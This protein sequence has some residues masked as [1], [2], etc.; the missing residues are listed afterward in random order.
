LPKTNCSSSVTTNEYKQFH[1]NVTLAKDSFPPSLSKQSHQLPQQQQ[2]QQHLDGATTKSQKEQSI[3]IKWEPNIDIRNMKFGPSFLSNEKR[4]KCSSFAVSARERESFPDKDMFGAVTDDASLNNNKL[5]DNGLLSNAS[6]ACLSPNPSVWTPYSVQNSDGNDFVHN[7]NGSASCFSMK[8][9]SARK[10]KKVGPLMAELRSLRGSIEGDWVRFQSGTYPYRDPSKRR[11]DVNDP[12]NRAEYY[13]DVTILSEPR[14]WSREG[15]KIVFLG[16][17][18]NKVRIKKRNEIVAHSSC[19]QSMRFRMPSQSI[20]AINTG[21]AQATS[22]TSET[23][24]NG[25]YQHDPPYHAWICFMRDTVR[26]QRITQKTQLRIYN[27]V[28]VSKDCFL[29]SSFPTVLCT[30]LCEPYP[31]TLPPLPEVLSTC[32]SALNLPS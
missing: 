7:S 1:G 12:R 17:I 23:N 5:R 14:S 20:A 19:S 28:I 16:Y 11:L 6:Q 3:G 32:D 4:S 24:D 27:A 10:R 30:Q 15:K 21:T 25:A 22:R 8:N 29:S 9:N 2:Q 26:E 31:S 18:H 13:V